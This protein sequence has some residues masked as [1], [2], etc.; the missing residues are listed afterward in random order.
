[1]TSRVRKRS[2]R[3]CCLSWAAAAGA[4]LQLAVLSGCDAPRNMAAIR[5]YYDY[6]FTETRDKLRPAAEVRDEQYI[7]NNLRLGLAA[8]A[9]GDN[10]EGAEVLHRTF[11]MLSTAGLNKDRTAAAVLFFEGVRIWKGEPF[12]QALA[13]YWTAVQYALLDDWENARAAAANSLFRLADFGSDQRADYSVTDSNFTLGFLMQATAAALSGAS[14]RDDLL[15]AATRI[16][17]GMQ[18]VA[19]VIRSGDYDTILMVDFGKG[20]TKTAYGADDS[21]TRFVPQERRRGPLIIRADGLELARADAVCDVDQLA[22]D[23]RWNN[24]ENVRKIKSATGNLLVAGGA[25]AVIIGADHDSN[26]AM[27]AGGAAILAG[28]LAKA[29]S[30]ADTRYLEFAPQSIYF[31]PVKVLRPCTLEVQVALGSTLS[32]GASG[33]IPTVGEPMPRVVLPDFRPGAPG[34][35]RAVYLRLHGDD[36][37]Q[38]AWLVGSPGNKAA[39]DD[40][41]VDE[42]ARLRPYSN[43]WLRICASG[44]NGGLDKENQE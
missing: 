35:P 20:P 2:I 30:H 18:S 28:L 7:L 37:S 32:G 26:E 6:R 43:G 39:S 10:R 23:L 36:S 38:P 4:I 34:R 25:A 9:D 42:N 29:G 13:Y 31:V 11:D 12:E 33:W 15:R 8:L 16:S 22:Q 21:L 1:M 41:F 27:I 24:L 44:S 17:P 19:D 40:V 5:D 3:V 14:G